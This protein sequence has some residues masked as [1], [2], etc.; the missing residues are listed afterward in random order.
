MTPPFRIEDHTGLAIFFAKKYGDYDTEEA[1]QDALLALWRAARTFNPALGSFSTYASTWARSILK[2]HRQYPYSMP[3]GM[4]DNAGRLGPQRERL[5]FSIDRRPSSKT[6]TG[7]HDESEY[8]PPATDEWG[9]NAQSDAADEIEHALKCLT[10][11]QQI[12]IRG[13]FLNHFTGH[14]VAAYLGITHQAVAQ[15]KDA[16]L[17]KM[18]HH[19]QCVRAQVG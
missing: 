7:S 6:H 2:R 15:I 10:K 4:S 3:F 18:R 9:T 17:T 12:V 19:L 14:E 13:I 16:A 8:I 1:A 11:R 5:L